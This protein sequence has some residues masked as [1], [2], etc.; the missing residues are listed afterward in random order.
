MGR[1]TILT[2][3]IQAKVVEALEIGSPRRAAAA[4]AGI[5]VS[6]FMLWMEKGRSDTD[7]SPSHEE[8][9][10][11]YAAVNAAEAKAEHKAIK[12]IQDV[13][14][15]ED[16]K[17]SLKAATWWLG[18]RRPDDWTAK[19]TVKIESDI[20]PTE[21]QEAAKAATPDERAQLKQHM[22]DAPAQDAIVRSILQR[23]RVG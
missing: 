1:P 18:V 5:S 4:F 10:E 2:P 11:F 8:Y 17:A 23:I 19:T 3:E 9:S 13:M 16:P 12:T 21:Y 7:D 22:G 14:G 20:T 6:S 15:G